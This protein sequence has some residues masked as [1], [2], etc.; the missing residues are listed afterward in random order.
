MDEQTFTCEDSATAVRVFGGNNAHLHLLE[1]GFGVD[2][3]VWGPSVAISG[4]A[5]AVQ[6]C[7]RVLERL[8]QLSRRGEGLH[9]Q[10]VRLVMREFVSSPD[11]EPARTAPILTHSGSRRA[12]TPRTPGQRDYVS[13]MGRSDLVFGVGPAGTGKSYLAVAVAVSR[14]LDHRVSRIVLTRPAVEA[15]EKLGFLP[16]D[17]EQ[18]INPYL[19]PMYDALHEMVDPARARAMMADGSIEVAPLAFMRGRT[20]KHSFVILDEAQNTTC[21]QMKMFLTRIGEGSTCVVNGDITQID[22]PPGR[23]SGLVQALS[24][25]RDVPGISVVRFTGA[26]VLR[27]PLVQRIV[28]AYER[29]G[30]GEGV[31]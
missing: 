17:L 28:E 13:A 15:G 8:R 30:A 27:H 7:M 31:Q 4:P 19:R 24:I 22:L 16:G 2:C 10:D 20:L 18:K 26:D 1:T 5:G 23:T 6:R 11:E 14:L 29:H 3:R 9:E 12:I 25:L 21:E